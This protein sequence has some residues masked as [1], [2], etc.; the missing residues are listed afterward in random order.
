MAAMMRTSTLTGARAAEARELSLLEDAQELHL[1]ASG[2]ISAISSRK[3]VPPS[4]SSK[5]PFAA[6]VRPG[7]RTALVPEELAL[8]QRLGKG[9]AVDLHERA[10]RRG[11]CGGGPGWR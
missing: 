3:S 8:E 5:R 10:A 2:D 1:R 4:A 6:T 7:E 9:R 11:R